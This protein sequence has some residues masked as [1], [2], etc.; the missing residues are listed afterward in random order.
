MCQR[1]LHINDGDD[2]Y[3]D[4]KEGDANEDEETV[5]FLP[6]SHQLLCVT[7]AMSGASLSSHTNAL[8]H[9][10]VLY[11]K[12]LMHCSTMYSTMMHCSTVYSSMMHDNTT[13]SQDSALL[14]V[15]P[16]STFV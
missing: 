6:Q 8:L 4:K 15:Q 11:Y 12:A 10:Y 14:L 13:Y 9:C 7:K 3:D 16:Y 2:N 5:V 1:R